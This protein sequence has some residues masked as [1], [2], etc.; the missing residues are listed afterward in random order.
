MQQLNAAL[1]RFVEQQ[2]LYNEAYGLFKNH[3]LRPREQHRQPDVDE[4]IPLSPELLY[5]YSHYEMMDEQAKG[6]LKM[7]NAAVEIGDAAL[8]SF[9]AP[10]HLH[11]QQLGYRWIGINEPY[12]ESASWHKS[13]VVIANYN[14]DPLIVDTAAP[15]SPVYAAL[16]GQEPQLIADSL[17]DFFTALS[18]LIEAARSY[19]GELKDEETYETKPE[20]LEHV[21]PVLNDLLGEEHTA[22]LFEYLSFR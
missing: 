21:E 20:Y 22:H 11:R 13:H 16:A 4:R 9:V 10:E 14:D 18:I 19:G 12:E 2:D 6:T 7:K 3:D 1:I 5:L 17:T 15:D 8:L